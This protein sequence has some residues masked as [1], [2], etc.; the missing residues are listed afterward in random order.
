MHV[1]SVIKTLG[2]VGLMLGELSTQIFWRVGEMSP[3]Q[4]TSPGVAQRP[5]ESDVPLWEPTVTSPT[6]RAATQA[7]LPMKELLLQCW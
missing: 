6:K 2:E 7:L 1:L 5:V 3:V 4:G